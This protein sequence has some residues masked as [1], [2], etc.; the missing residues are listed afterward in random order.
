LIKIDAQSGI[1][2]HSARAHTTTSFESP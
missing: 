1:M 2:T